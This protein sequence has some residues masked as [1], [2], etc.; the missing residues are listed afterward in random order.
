MKLVTFQSFDAVKYL[1]EKGYLECNESKINLAK[2]GHTYKWVVDEM[3]KFVIND[4]KISYPIWCWV[5]CFNNVCPSKRKGEKVKGY[6]VKITFHKDEKD[7]FITD[8]RRFSFLLNNTYI[9]DS[10]DDKNKFNK[11]LIKHNITQDELKAY[12]RSDK[13]AEHRTDKEFLRICGEIRE[14]FSKCITKDSDILQG[15]VWRVYL[16]DIENIEILKDDG[17]IYGSI[18]YIRS[19]GERMNWIEDYY[20]KIED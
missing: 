13:Y 17:Y 12:V 3:N 1:F 16:K 10:L 8:F 6:D 18:N 4:F 2:S 14:S 7:V 5:K 9:P 15:C 19:N 20:R 11:K